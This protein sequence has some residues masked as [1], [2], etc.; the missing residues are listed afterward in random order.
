MVSSE[1]KIEL[2]A[3]FGMLC[4]KP[5]DVDSENVQD[6]RSTQAVKRYQCRSLPCLLIV[7]GKVEGLESGVLECSWR[8]WVTDVATV[9]GLE[10]L[11]F[12]SHR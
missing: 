8:G 2:L 5:C 11:V 10:A 1:A 9:A 12:K 3:N 4:V 7:Q 6:C